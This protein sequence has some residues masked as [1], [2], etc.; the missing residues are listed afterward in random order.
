M[1]AISVLSRAGQVELCVCADN[2]CLKPSCLCQYIY[3]YTHIQLYILSFE[4]IIISIWY[5]YI[6]DHIIADPH[7]DIWSYQCSSSAGGFTRESQIQMIQLLIW[8]PNV[9]PFKLGNISKLICLVG[10]EIPIYLTKYWDNWIFGIF[11]DQISRYIPVKSNKSQLLIVNWITLDYITFHS[12]SLHHIT[13]T[14]IYIHIYTYA[15]RCTD[16]IAHSCWFVVWTADLYMD[17]VQLFL[18]L[19]QLLGTL[20]ELVRE[21]PRLCRG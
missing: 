6:Y 20:A 1:A 14:Y 16:H 15:H 11:A 3:I 13:Y 12:I 18:Y 10:W 9:I 19:L 2:T 8:C 17:I 4:I 21:N 5:I 7:I